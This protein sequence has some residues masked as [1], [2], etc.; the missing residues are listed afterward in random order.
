MKVIILGC[1][2]V[3]SQIANMLDLEG[4]EVSVIDK[5]PNA[6]DRLRPEF[7][8]QKIVGLGF[9]R[10]TLLKAG[11]ETADAFVA[12]ARGDN[13]NA[14]SAFIA[15]NYFHVPKVI[16]RI[17]DS[18][19]AKI[20]WQMGINT[21]APVSWAVKQ[22]KDFLFQKEEEPLLEFGAGEVKVVKCSCLGH[23]SGK[24]VKD[25]EDGKHIKLVALIRKGTA[26]LPP[27]GHMLEDGDEI[28]LSVDE[29][30]FNKINELLRG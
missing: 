30:G 28:V 1:G 16:A 18:E 9:D 27:P 5:D 17:Y 26:I 10:N 15:R 11:I 3:G 7:K 23:L 4:H 19:R 20:Y 6:F 2:R 12:T 29:V 13:H 8:G 21:I 14:V 25:I 24:A 22:I